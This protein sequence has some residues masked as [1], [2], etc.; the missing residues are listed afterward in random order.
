[1]DGIDFFQVW[2]FLMLGK[3]DWLAKRFVQLP[4]APERNH[5]QIITLLK[6]RLQPFDV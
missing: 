4:G 1:F 5:D 6:R 3:L 2:F